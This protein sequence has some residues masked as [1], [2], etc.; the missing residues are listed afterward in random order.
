MARRAKVKI[1]TQFCHITHF[2]GSYGRS[3]YL[4]YSYVFV[5]EFSLYLCMYTLAYNVAAVS[6]QAY[7]RLWA[8]N[9]EE[10]AKYIEGERERESWRRREKSI[11]FLF[12]FVYF[13]WLSFPFSISEKKICT[14]DH[15]HKSVYLATRPE[16]DFHYQHFF[17]QL[18]ILSH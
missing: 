10:R 9:D 12:L 8:S 2:I 7:L 15:F 3:V 5:L 4:L 17:H 6:C 11:P 16:L 18:C 14:K 13:T 1:Y